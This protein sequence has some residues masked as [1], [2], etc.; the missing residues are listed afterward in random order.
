MFRLPLATFHPLTLHSNP[1]GRKGTTGVVLGLLCPH[2]DSAWG[3][4][5]TLLLPSFP[6]VLPQGPSVFPGKSRAA[7][8]GSFF[9]PLQPCQVILSPPRLTNSAWKS[10]SRPQQKG[11][12]ELLHFI[13][14]DCLRCPVRGLCGNKRH[15]IICSV[16]S[17]LWR[18]IVLGGTLHGGSRT[19]ECRNHRS[20]R[21]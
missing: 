17:L 13:V 9:Q 5:L 3:S 14:A 11:G 21:G 7:G 8:K 12:N 19:G 20:Q 2:R 10:Q 15:L 16:Y 6:R 4:I 1:P 18:W